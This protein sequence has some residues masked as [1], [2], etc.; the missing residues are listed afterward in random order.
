MTQLLDHHGLPAIALQAKDGARAVVELK[1]QP[2]PSRLQNRLRAAHAA[3]VR[4]ATTTNER[5]S[6]GP[7]STGTPTFVACSAQRYRR[8]T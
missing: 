3:P 8:S 4:G 5:R 2:P 7:P 6:T 1:R